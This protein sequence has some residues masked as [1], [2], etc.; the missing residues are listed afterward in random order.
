MRARV[1]AEAR[2]RESGGGG[3]TAAGGGG[4]AAAAAGGVGPQE[5]D[6][7]VSSLA[8]EAS[9]LE[10]RLLQMVV[11]AEQREE[12]LRG[13]AQGQIAALRSHT[14]ALQADLSARAGEALNWHGVAEQLATEHR[15]AAVHAALSHTRATR[16]ARALAAWRVVVVARV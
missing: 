16:L 2:L 10:R 1:A 3:G 8:H 9:R 14:Q 6:A 11:W 5:Q 7:L 13:A 15:D 12:M 4:T